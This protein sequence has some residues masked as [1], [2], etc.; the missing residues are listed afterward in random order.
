MREILAG[1]LVSMNELSTQGGGYKS[2]EDKGGCQQQ[3]EKELR[4]S[5]LSM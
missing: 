5:V 2:R 4:E 1:G 3:D